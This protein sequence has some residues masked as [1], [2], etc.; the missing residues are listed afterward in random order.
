MVHKPS[1][2]KAFSSGNS[3]SGKVILRKRSLQQALERREAKSF[4]G[5]IN[6]VHP[7]I[8]VG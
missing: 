6:L 3:K 5:K 8:A 2:Y 1:W 4:Y 7:S